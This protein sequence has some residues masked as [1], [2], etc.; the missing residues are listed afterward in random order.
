MK[1]IL[2]LIAA[3]IAFSASWGGIFI[4]VV[5]AALFFPL[6]WLA[7]FILGLIWHWV[8]YFLATALAALANE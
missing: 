7:Y 3:L 2:G 4:L 1:N 6:H 5:L 8:G